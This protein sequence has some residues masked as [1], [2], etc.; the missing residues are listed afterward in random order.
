MENE[1]STLNNIVDDAQEYFNA[2]QELAT[3]KIAE[4]SS[5]AISGAASGL[6]LGGILMLIILFSSVALA[7]ALSN[8]FASST[9]GFLGVAGLYLL[10]LLIL[11]FNK[12]NWLITPMTN[13][14]IKNY[15]KEDKDAGN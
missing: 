5:K 4:K 8:Y 9:M 12:E 7:F 14:I 6:L 3:L 2:R 10:I 11:F 13:T 1:N 15:F